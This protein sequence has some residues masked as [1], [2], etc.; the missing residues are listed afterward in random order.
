MRLRLFHVLCCC[1][2]ALATALAFST[3]DP[4]SECFD[5]YQRKE[6]AVVW[7]FGKG[8]SSDHPDGHSNMFCRELEW[9]HETAVSD[10]AV[11]LFDPSVFLHLMRHRPLIIAGDSLSANLCIHLQRALSEYRIDEP[12]YIDPF[13]QIWYGL[14]QICHGSMQKLSLHWKAQ[15]Q[16]RARTRPRS[17]RRYSCCLGMLPTAV[18]V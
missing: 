11:P 6:Q 2:L 10:C 14:I 18:V 8:N 7:N 1:R 12:R 5:E 9:S 3:T 4:S 16:M 13:D 15:Q 17:H